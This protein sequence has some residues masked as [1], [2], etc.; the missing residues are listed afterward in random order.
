MTSTT[1]PTTD[2]VLVRA[3]EIL[4]DPERVV[5]DPGHLYEEADGTWTHYPDRR[6]RVCFMGAIFVAGD[7]LG[8]PSAYALDRV[9]HVLDEHNLTGFTHTLRDQG[10]EFCAA[11]IDETRR[12]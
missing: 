11:L 12:S 6:A 2:D 8:F 10:P 3:A 9:R 5:K 1:I 7:E 4:R